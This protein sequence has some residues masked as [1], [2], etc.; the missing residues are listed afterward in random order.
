MPKRAGPSEAGNL[1]LTRVKV[2]KEMSTCTFPEDN[3]P[4]MEKTM[5]ALPDK[6]TK[7]LKVKNNVVGVL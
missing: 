2:R 6:G 7:F 3:E 4:L 5:D 1:I